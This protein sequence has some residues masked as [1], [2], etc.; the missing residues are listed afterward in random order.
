MGARDVAPDARRLF[1][2][3]SAKFRWLDKQ[4]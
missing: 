3:G 1:I 4:F 2:S